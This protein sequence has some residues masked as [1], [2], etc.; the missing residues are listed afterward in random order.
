[1]LNCVGL[2]NKVLSV[3]LKIGGCQHH[4]SLNWNKSLPNFCAIF[5]A[6]S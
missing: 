3:L 2:R 6:P 4:R 5:R 1:M